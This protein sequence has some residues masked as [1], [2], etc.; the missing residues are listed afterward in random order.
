MAELILINP[1]YFPPEKNRDR[2]QRFIEY[3]RGGNM[4]FHPFEPP[5]GLASLVSYLKPRGY[6]CRLI[7]MPADELTDKR[8]QRDLSISSAPRFIGITAMTTTMRRALE[9][10]QICKSVFPE[11][12]LVMGGVHPTIRPDAVLSSHAVDFVIR[13]EGEEAMAMLM[14]SKMKKRTYEIPGLCFKTPDCRVHIAKKTALISDLD[15]LPLPDYT[16]FPALSYVGYTQEL[17]GIRAISMLIS[18]GCPYNCSFC[19]V[20]QTMGRRSRIKSPKRVSNEMDEVLKLLDLEGIWFK[21]SIFNLNR[22]WVKSF[23]EY[24]KISPLEGKFQI[25]TR[26]DLVREDDLARM[27]EAGLV[28]IDLGIESGSSKTLKTLRKA[29]SPKQVRKV[30]KM[31]KNYVRISGFF[32]IGVPGETEEDIDMTFRLAQDLELD[33]ASISI[34]APLPGSTLYD[35][36]ASQGKL[37][38]NEDEVHFTEATESYCEVPIQRLKER[39]FEFNEKFA[40]Q[41]K[42]K[43]SP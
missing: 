11:V 40:V 39:F 30:I 19:A 16:S 28:Q 15:T 41:C 17:R 29:I 43:D 6:E 9:I 2:G 32:M 23:C 27:A 35:E 25:N 8:L 42:P 3:I 13:A 26:V 33:S 34:F 22:D 12:P 21:D 18:R 1:S 4:Y 36:L 24:R 20:H 7:D 31:A 10:A 5:L 14:A 38:G 37:R